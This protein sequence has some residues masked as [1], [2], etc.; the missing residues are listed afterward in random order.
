MPWAENSHP[1]GVKTVIV[2]YRC[3]ALVHGRELVIPSA[4]S[5]Y[6]SRFATVPLH[7]VL[8]AMTRP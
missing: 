4:M 2:D 8:A 6:A 7:Y 1:F 5:D 3:G